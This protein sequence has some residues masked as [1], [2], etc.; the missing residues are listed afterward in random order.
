MKRRLDAWRLALRWQQASLARRH[1]LAFQEMFLNAWMRFAGILPPFLVSTS[2]SEEEGTE[3]SVD[4]ESTSDQSGHGSAGGT[5]MALATRARQPAHERDAAAIGAPT[6]QMNT[7]EQEAALAATAGSWRALAEERNRARIRSLFEHSVQMYHRNANLELAD[8]AVLTGLPSAHEH[9]AAL[10]AMTGGCR[11]LSGERSR[12]SVL[13]PFDQSVQRE[14]LRGHND[15]E[16]QEV[17]LEL[18]M[19]LV[20]DLLTRCIPVVSRGPGAVRAFPGAW[21]AA[22]LEEISPLDVAALPNSRS[23]RAFPRCAC[24]Y[25]FAR[26]RSWPGA[27]E[28][29][30]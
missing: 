9:E 26:P 22:R 29:V 19:Q 25:V 3:A 21:V 17:W 13:R 2:E 1:E 18:W 28:E 5:P 10:A 11:A 14:S 16:P 4:S 6:G 20:W 27:Y 15:E 8:R 24:L 12:A 7:Y 30:D 23:W